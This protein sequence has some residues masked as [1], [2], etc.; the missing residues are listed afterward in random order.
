[1]KLQRFF[2]WVAILSMVAH[3]AQPDTE[4][5]DLEVTLM[6]PYNH[7]FTM[8]TT[9]RVAQAFELTATNGAITNKVSGTLHAPTNGVYPLDLTV[10]ECASENSNIRDAMKLNL[11]LGKAWCGGPVSSFLYMRHV[12]I[13]RHVGVFTAMNMTTIA[14][15]ATT[16]NEV[17]TWSVPTNGLQARL[18]LVERSKENGT[19][20]LVPYL[21]LRNVRN[22][23]NQM[24]V[25]CDSHHLKIELVDADG[26]VIR[27]GWLQNRSGPRAELSTINLPLDSSIRIS[28][29]CRNWGVPR[30]AAAMVATD[31]GAWVIQQSEKGKVFLRATLTGDKPAVPPYCMTWYGT[32]QTPLLN[33]DWK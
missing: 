9:V 26:K 30:D 3:A 32:I 8:Q 21:E 2:L 12:T 1:M 33:I 10:S 20:W 15:A 19:R 27:D 6:T 5:F 29:E 25:Q 23:V 16:T 7:D 31:S 14:P 11:E 13:R 17:D 28:L 22:L 24:E 4:S 18:T